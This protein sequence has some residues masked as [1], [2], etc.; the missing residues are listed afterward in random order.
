[1]RLELS[2]AGSA[3]RARLRMNERLTIGSSS[4]SQLS[5]N[6]P[7]LSPEHFSIG[8]TEQG[9]WVRAAKGLEIHL[10]G[11]LCSQATLNDGD[12]IRV[13][14]T[15]FQLGV[16]GF[17]TETQEDELPPYTYSCSRFENG[18]WIIE[19][20]DAADSPTQLF[21]DLVGDQSAYLMIN[22]RQAGQTP[23]IVGA[24]FF[25]AASKD[26]RAEFSLHCLK[27]TSEEEYSQL[28][29]PLV[30]TDSALLIISPLSKEELVQQ[31]KFHF[32]WFA[33]PSLLKFHL[34]RGNADLTASLL[35]DNL[36]IYT[37]VSSS[38]DWWS[39]QRGDA[40][41]SWKLFNLPHPPL[42]L[43]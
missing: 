8:I 18:I 30:D 12:E 4:L 2:V 35:G 23:A 16:T 13:G 1:M 36:R 31:L 39:A 6:E 10:N 41:A 29:E 5:V 34:T 14:G 3:E 9:A 37:K 20:L 38:G 19:S 28:I 40:D 32:A 43:R 33:K 21:R 26:I 11:M 7:A 17:D 42:D 27:V 22:Y 24:D 25:Q 15:I